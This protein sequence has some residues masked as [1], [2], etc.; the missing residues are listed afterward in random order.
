MPDINDP[1]LHLRLLETM[2]E[3]IARELGMATIEADD[4]PFDQEGLAQ[5]IS[6][7]IEASGAVFCGHPDADERMRDAARVLA[8]FAESTRSP[9][10]PD[11]ASSCG[12]FVVRFIA[13][14]LA[15][16]AAAATLVKLFTDI[17][18]HIDAHGVPD[19][20][21]MLRPHNRDDAAEVDDLLGGM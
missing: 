15:L 14:A 1:R 12:M 21:T 7:F 11:N 17:S 9:D 3:T 8:R 20:P 10:I 16:S 5:A 19:N 4:S 6:P 18:D 13:M 2:A